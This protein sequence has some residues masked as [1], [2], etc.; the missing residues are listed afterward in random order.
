MN[1]PLTW[2]RLFFKFIACLSLFILRP[3]NLLALNLVSIPP[4]CPVTWIYLFALFETATSRSDYVVGWIDSF[5]KGK[6]LG[7][8][9]IH[10][11]RY[12]GEN[13]D[14]DPQK[15]LNP[16]SQE[17]P[18]RIFGIFPKSWMWLLLLPFTNRPGMRFVNTVKYWLGRIFDHGKP[19]K[20]GLVAFNFLLDYIPNWKKVYLPGGFI[21]HQS[22]IPAEYARKVV[23]QIL[24]ITHRHRIPPY[25]AVFKRHRKDAFLLSHGLDGY[26][27]ALDFPIDSFSRGRILEMTRELDGLICSCGG[28]FYAAKDATL[29][30]ESF[31]ASLPEDAIRNFLA[32]KTKLDP[33][34][35]I[36]TDLGNRYFQDGPLNPGIL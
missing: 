21:Q 29:Q 33:Q 7:R 13:E 10:E 18:K 19:F 20:Q 24:E 36:Q 22:F 34:N 9:L 27:L 17:L 8:G 5:A 26:S 23:P 15:S 25:L 12:L 6:S 35:L 16:K 1:G 2:P 11:A 28:R 32:L 30:G 4:T 14:T 31:R 3:K